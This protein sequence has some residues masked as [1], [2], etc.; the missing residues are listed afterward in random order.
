MY[1]A[2]PLAADAVTL[3]TTEPGL[4]NLRSIDRRI[5]VQHGL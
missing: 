1:N 5:V 2:P 3:A 4:P